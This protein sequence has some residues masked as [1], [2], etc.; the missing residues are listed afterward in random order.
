LRYGNRQLRALALEGSWL[1]GPVQIDARRA[2]A[3]AAVARGLNLGLSGVADAAPLLGLL[4]H[5]AAA[6]RVDGQLAW[7]GTA[8]RLAGNDAWQISLASN[9]SGL[10][11]R[12]PEPFDKA[13]ARALPV[14]AQLR[15]D[16][17]GLRGFEIDGERVSVRGQVDGRITAANFEIGGV[18]GSLRRAANADPQLNFETLELR[19]RSRGAATRS[20][21]HSSRRRRRSIN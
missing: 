3:T 8:Q 6:E 2:P 9:L 14:N 12:L 7:S 11:S 1:G 17:N 10:E 20:N 16:A 15:V 4:G 18:S 13:R 19:R 5:G 21:F